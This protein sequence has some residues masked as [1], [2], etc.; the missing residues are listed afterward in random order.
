MRVKNIVSIVFII[1]LAG[2]ASV[3]KETV[4]L[5]QTIGNDL[6]VLQQ[7][8]RNLAELYFNKI[9]TDINTFV[10]DVY[11]PFVIHYVLNKELQSF[12]KG[13]PSLY[14]TLELAGQKE[15]KQ[16]SENAVNEMANFQNSA[17]KQ[18]EK[19]RAELL[20]PIL[21]QETELLK[22]IN[23][24]YLQVNN[25]NTSVTIYLQSLRKL[26]EE[27]GQALSIV[28]LAGADTLVGN[29]LANFSEQVEEVL[30][31]GKEIDVK[32]DDAYQKLQELTNKIKSLTSKK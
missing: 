17:R 1:L 3:P 13:E 4:L 11:A 7:S 10:D 18:I 23:K 9:K 21:I 16:E 25:A 29:S 26:K 27:Q 14:G 20:N 31:R 28:G 6:Q 24:S 22:A 8:H 30:K 32:S 15:G 2:C 19:K 5:S 12:K